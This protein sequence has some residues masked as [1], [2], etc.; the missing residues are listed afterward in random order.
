MIIII[1]FTLEQSFQI[2]HFETLVKTNFKNQWKVMKAWKITI[3]TQ[4][5]LSLYV[6]LLSSFSLSLSNTNLWIKIQ[7]QIYGLEQN[8]TQICILSPFLLMFWW[9]HWFL[10]WNSTTK[11][12]HVP[13]LFLKWDFKICIVHAWPLTWKK[14]TLGFGLIWWC[15][16][17]G[18][19]R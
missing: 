6:D 12:R 16:F 3:T 11:K 17:W 13:I 15:N 19:F 7:I 8:Q 14:N 18:Y 10:V 9:W 2:L 4:L 1:I 5:I